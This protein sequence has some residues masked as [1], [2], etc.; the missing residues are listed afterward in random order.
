MHIL[1]GSQ[2]LILMSA[3]IF[4]PHPN[5]A[6]ANVWG[7]Y[8]TGTSFP[9]AWHNTNRVAS[10]IIECKSACAVGMAWFMEMMRNTQKQDPEKI[11][12]RKNTKGGL[13]NSTIHN[14]KE[15]GIEVKTGL[16]TDLTEIVIGI[17]K[18]IETGTKTGDDILETRNILTTGMGKHNPEP[19]GRICSSMHPLLSFGWTYRKPNLME[20][21]NW[22]V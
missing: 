1:D 4:G 5:V 21:L 12:M 14:L 8:W 6:I 15:R 18:L 16:G 11:G 19:Q 10:E 9:K 20:G 3:S 13:H 7:I 17:G 2:G 22:I